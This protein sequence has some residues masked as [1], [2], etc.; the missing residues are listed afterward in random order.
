[1]ASHFRFFT[2]AGIFGALTLSV[3]TPSTE[4]WTSGTTDIQPFGAAHLGIDNY[5]TMFRKIAG[6]AGA[7]PADLGVTVGILPFSK[8]NMEIGIDI[9]EPLDYPLFGNAKIGVPEGAFFKGQPGVAAGIFNAGTKKE[10]TDYNIGYAAIGKTVPLL[11]RLFI[12]G[13]MGKRSTLAGETNRGISVAWDRAFLPAKS[14]CGADFNRLL[15]CA[16]WASGKNYYGGGG[17]GLAW[18]F[19]ENISVLTGPVF[20]NDETLNGKWKWTAQFDA[21]VRLRRP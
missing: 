7:F 1:M 18:F 5:F 20:F 13:Y 17:F 16:D 4:L 8:V 6:G 10:L 2:C 14:A 19:T 11:G 3:A 15:L 9:M 12:G 21:N